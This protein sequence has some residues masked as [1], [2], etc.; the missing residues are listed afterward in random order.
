MEYQL[1]HRPAAHEVFGNN[2]LHILGRHVVVPNPVWL[3]THHRPT[4]ARRET[5]NPRPLDAQLALVEASRREPPPEAVKQLLC[6]TFLRASGPDANQQVTA[7][8]TDFGLFNAQAGNPT[9]ES[10]PVA[11]LCKFN[12]RRIPPMSR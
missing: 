4:P 5:M 1:L 8:I 6:L 7:L 9:I 10:T 2:P 11:S 12:N 3:H